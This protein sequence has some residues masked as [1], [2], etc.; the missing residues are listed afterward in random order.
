MLCG[1]RVVYSINCL[2]LGSLL[3]SWCEYRKIHNAITYIPD[4]IAVEIMQ[5]EETSEVKCT[6][7]VFCSHVFLNVRLLSSICLRSIRNAGGLYFTMLIDV[8]SLYHC[9]E[10]NK[11]YTSD[12]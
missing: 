11:S 9:Q 1:S 7:V 5:R 10:S 4:A 12:E 8:M 6:Y 3:Q 2:N